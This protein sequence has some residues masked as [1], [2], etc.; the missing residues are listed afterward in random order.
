MNKIKTLIQQ[1]IKEYRASTGLTLRQFAKELGAS[2]MSISYWERGDRIPSVDAMVSLEA[3]CAPTHKVFVANLQLLVAEYTIL[4]I[5]KTF[6][7]SR[8]A[9]GLS[10][11]YPLYENQFSSRDEE[12]EQTV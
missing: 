8:V 1:H 3:I 4:H 10:I 11:R 12:G 6:N 5:E 9:I 2:H 7:M